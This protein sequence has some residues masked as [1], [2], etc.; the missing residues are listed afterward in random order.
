MLTRVPRPAWSFEN[1]TPEQRRIIDE[2]IRA[3]RKADEGDAEAWSALQEGLEAGIPL[4]AFAQAIGRSRPTYY[5]R[6]E[7]IRTWWQSLSEEDR[8][9]FLAHRDSGPLPADV[10]RRFVDSGQMIAGAK[11]VGSGDGYAFHWPA[12]I[13]DLL[14]EEAGE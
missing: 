11:W 4:D 1:A 6:Q 2:G 8:N 10:V 12:D 13:A 7:K 9:L 5:R 14:D 3:A